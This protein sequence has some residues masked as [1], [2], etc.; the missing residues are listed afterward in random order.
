MCFVAEQFTRLMM[1]QLMQQQQQQSSGT[2]NQQA[3]QGQSLP[4]APRCLDEKAKIS[5]YK[6]R[7]CG[8]FYKTKYS[9]RRHEKNEC[10]VKPQ[11][12]CEKCEFK[13]KYKHNLKSHFKIRHTDYHSQSLTITQRSSIRQ[14]TTGQA[15]S[16]SSLAGSSNSTTTTTPATTTQQPI[17]NPNVLNLNSNN[18]DIT[19]LKTNNIP[20]YK[21][22]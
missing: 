15:S 8:K 19:L 4:F 3:T 13:T 22:E 12:H 16:S 5:F 11:Y 18:S 21:Q 2:G 10:G 14:A 9:W 17:V 20:M 1:L 6:C 7:K